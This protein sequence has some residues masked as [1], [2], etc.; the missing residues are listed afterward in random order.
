[1]EGKPIPLQSHL[2]VQL[3]ERFSPL[4]TQDQLAALLGRTPGGL[5]WPRPSCR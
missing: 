5:R 4:L 3:T 1:M 2:S